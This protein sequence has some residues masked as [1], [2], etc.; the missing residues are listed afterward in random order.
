MDQ[1]K[2]NPRCCMCN[3]YC[4]YM[5]DKGTPYGCKDPDWPEPLDPEYWCEKCA[6]K[7][8]ERALKDG[9]DMYLYWEV[10]LWQQ[11]AMKKLGL[12][13]EHHKLVKI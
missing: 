3:K 9:M 8:Y 12:R 4:G 10:P 1:R 11:K 13:K 2:Y 5:A 7:E 6:K